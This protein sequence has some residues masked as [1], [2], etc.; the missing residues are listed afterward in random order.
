MK[1]TGDLVTVTTTYLHLPGRAAF[2]PAFSAGLDLLVLEAREALP[3]FYRFLYGTVGRDFHWTDRLGWS[4]E[5][6]TS[7]LGRPEVTLLPLYMR[8]TP[9]GYIELDRASN[10]E[11][12]GTE[13]VYFGLF[14]AFH[15][16]G[17]GKHL[18]S[19]G[20]QRAFDDGAAR[21]WLHACSLDGPHA[22]AN[23]QARGFVPYKTETHQER[24]GPSDRQVVGP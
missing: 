14:P 7:Y 13:V 2:R 8:G 3:A 4:D 5:Q 15:G 11:E 20:V 18:L 9:A 10:P 21:V 16:R 6:I 23:Y 19:A 17:L 24:I 12:E 22:L 1:T